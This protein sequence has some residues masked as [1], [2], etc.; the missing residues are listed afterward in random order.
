[1]NKDKKKE[2]KINNRN[3]LQKSKNKSLFASNYK[4]RFNKSVRTDKNSNH[5]D[6]NLKS[7]KNLLNIKNNNKILNRY[8]ISENNLNSLK[9]N[10]Y[11]VPK[12]KEKIPYNILLSKFEKI[13]EQTRNLSNLVE[14]FLLDNKDIKVKSY[15]DLR[16]TLDALNPNQKEVMDKKRDIENNI[17]GIAYK[18]FFKNNFLS[19]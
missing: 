7:N 17:K 5:L 8:E 18:K 4:N 13:Q 19:Y 14:N 3:K 6:K 1:M 2:R 12:V 15:E 9:E 16:D 11:Y 10:I